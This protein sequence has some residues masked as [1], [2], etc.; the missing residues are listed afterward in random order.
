MNIFKIIKAKLYKLFLR[1]KKH[2]D[3]SPSLNIL[4]V[5][6]QDEEQFHYF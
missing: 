6:E 3:D 1:I 4:S 5:E 2:D